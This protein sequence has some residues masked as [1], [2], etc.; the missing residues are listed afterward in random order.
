MPSNENEDQDKRES[1]ERKNENGRKACLGQGGSAS[2]FASDAGVDRS[3]A[4]AGEQCLDP[5]KLHPVGER[6]H[7]R[8]LG[9]KAELSDKEKGGEV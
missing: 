5:E 7:R 9:R 8:V 2:S 1:T 4:S 3:G 6:E